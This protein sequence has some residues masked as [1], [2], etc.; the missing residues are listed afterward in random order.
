MHHRLLLLAAEHGA[1]WQRTLLFDLDQTF[2]ELS[3]ERG[4]RGRSVRA[5]Y[6]ELW[7]PHPLR[8]DAWPPRG[9]PPQPWSR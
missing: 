2:Q 3:A 6:G 1:R 8:V 9:T 5:L 7:Q 4:G